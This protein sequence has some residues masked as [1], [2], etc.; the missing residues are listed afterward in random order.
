VY[1]KYILKEKKKG[2]KKEE[3]ERKTRARQKG[4]S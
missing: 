3:A 2:E 1:I 4:E